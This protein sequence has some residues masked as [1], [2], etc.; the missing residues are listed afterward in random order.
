MVR[1]R[2]YTDWVDA[3]KAL[4]RSGHQEQARDLLVE[5]CAA[6]EAEATVTGQAIPP[7][8]FEQCAIVCRKLRDTNDEAAVLKRYIDK[9]LA[10]S[11]VLEDRLAALTRKQQI[12]AMGATP[13]PAEPTRPAVYSAGW[14]QDPWAHAALRYYDGSQWTGYVANELDQA[15]E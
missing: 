11:G 8:Y 6:A 15:G 1:G 14:Y 3:V 5:L 7:W 12:P 4:K 9:P 10:S 2:H 13:A